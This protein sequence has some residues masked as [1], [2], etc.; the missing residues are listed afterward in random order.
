MAGMAATSQRSGGRL[1][2]VLVLVVFGAGDSSASLGD[3]LFLPDWVWI[4]RAKKVPAP[5]LFAAQGTSIFETSD[6]SRL[7]L[8]S[9]PPDLSLLS[10]LVSCLLPGL[11]F[12]L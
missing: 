7:A 6:P 2:L 11:D 8:S 5:R 1:V 12:S 4:S 9:P 10:P 3:F